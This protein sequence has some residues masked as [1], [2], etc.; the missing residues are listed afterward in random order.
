L[1][2][3]T[4]SGHGG[5]KK[6]SDRHGLVGV[7]GVWMLYDRSLFDAEMHEALAEF[8]PN[9]RVL[10]VSDSC[11]GGVPEAER[12]EQPSPVAASV[13]VMTACGRDQ[14]ADAGDLPGHF[15]NALLGAWDNGGLDGGYRRFHEAIAARMPAYQTPDYYWVGRPDPGFEAQRPF[16]V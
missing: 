9:V 5:R 10:V 13:L 4:F 6:G 2:V 8:R 16:T 7:R 3:L 11:N 12:D 15:T 14:F 1:F